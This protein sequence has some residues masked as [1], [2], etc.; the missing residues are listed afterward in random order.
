MISAN[1]LYQE[2]GSS[3]SFKEWLEREKAKGNFIPNA[4]ALEQFHSID[5]N[6]ENVSEQSNPI[7][8]VNLVRNMAI[9]GVLLVVAYVVISRKN[10]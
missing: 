9:L 1:K 5:A 8:G 10:K 6:D 4:N 3:L 2:S 7:G